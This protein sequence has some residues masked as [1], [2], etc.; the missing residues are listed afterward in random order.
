MSVVATVKVYDG[1]VLGAE[2]MTQLM[3]TVPG[4][5]GPQLVKAYENAQKLFQ[6]GKRPIGILTYGIGNIGRRSVESLVDEFSRAEKSRDN[7]PVN[8]EQSAR[9]FY[10]FLRDR[11][12][13]AFGALP[14]PQQPAMGFVV[15]GYSDGEPLGSQWEFVLPMAT[16]PVSVGPQD[17]VGA[18]WRGVA[19]PFFRLMYGVDPGLEQKLR[20]QGATD[21]EIQRFKN[22]MP[23]IA[24]AVAFDGMPLADAVSYCRFIIQTTIGWC[25]YALGQ[26]ACGGPIKLATITPGDGFEWVTRPKPYLEG[27]MSCKQ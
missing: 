1:I 15:A 12:T 6:V 26:A 11:Y 7:D 2:S 14:Q 13:P 5:P 8:V 17:S 21:Q 19:N 20:Q 18:M 22:A 3:A 9:R 23:Q 10:D 4:M 16:G 27:E 24:T 25:M